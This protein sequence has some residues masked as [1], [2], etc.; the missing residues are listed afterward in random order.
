MH[1]SKTVVSL[2]SGCGGMDLGF[3]G[4]FEVLSRSINP[5]THPNLDGLRVSKK[6]WVH[7]P[8]TGFKTIFANDITRRAYSSWIPYF[9]KRGISKRAFHLESIVDLVKHHHD[10]QHP[11]TFPSADVVTGGFPCQDFSLAGKRK[12]LHSHRDHRGKLRE[13]TDEI[14]EATAENR[15]QLYMWMKQ[16]VDIVRPAV[17]VAENVKGLVSLDQVKTIIENDFKQIGSGFIV[18]PARVLNASHFGV[19]QNRHRVIFL[20]LNRD[21]MH[22]EALSLF[23]QMD[24]V[25]LLDHLNPYPIQS[26]APSK[27]VEQGESL[28][29]PVVTVGECLKGLPE[30]HQAK[31]PT[32][33]GY[34]RAKWY[35]KH[36]QG[37]TEVKLDDVG[38]T[39]RSEHHGN[40]E[41]RRLHPDHGGQYNREFKRGR[42]E[43]RLTVRECARI[44]TFPD[45]FKFV[46]P[47]DQRKDKRYRLSVSDGYK[48]VGNAVP[49]L[50]AFHLA[51][52]LREIWDDLFRQ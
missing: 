2:F 4:D 47:T 36:C 40:I 22:P 34:S 45:Q 15:G 18:L 3:E 23:D 9:S 46:R 35:G 17:F 16:V 33:Q 7:L 51:W 8:K 20:G 39:I 29:A 21:R 5:K 49:P 44:Q 50:L 1:Y 27:G 37:Q 6:G 12:G 43:R 10:P 31:D 26:H 19:P 11:F 42:K 30:P 14:E 41:F 24:R 13:E 38:P 48:V 32:Q 28:C 25:P 52:R